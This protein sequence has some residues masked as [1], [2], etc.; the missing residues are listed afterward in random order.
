VDG[1]WRLNGTKAYV[2]N[3]LVSDLGIITAVSDPD[4]KRNLRLSAFLVDLHQ[5]GVQRTRLN[6][7]VWIPSDLTRLKLTDVFVP[8][9]HLLGIRGRGLQQVLSIFTH[10]R[11]TISALT[12]GTA[13]GAFELALEHGKR[14]EIFDQKLIH[15]QAKSFEAADFFAKIEAVRLMIQK[16]CWAMDHQQDFR[17]ESSLAKYLAV[18][19][20]REV[21]TW[22]ADMFGAA[23][24][25]L[26]H[27]IH[28]FPMDAWASALG[29]GTQDVQKL[30]IFR[31]ALKRYTT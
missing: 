4:A 7:Q 27:P 18:G 29:E 6:K 19:V 10:S 20:A 14:R 15:F 5:K 22:A 3:G 1:G 16:A 9:D 31:E 8:D 24:V 25:M 30:V 2:T 26:E 28:K 23:S 11:V 17:L 12:L 21:A 13:I